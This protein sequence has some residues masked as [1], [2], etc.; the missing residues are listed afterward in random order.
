MTKHN[1][2]RMKL[3]LNLLVICSGIGGILYGYDIGVISGALV[4]MR[5]TISMTDSQVGLLVGSVLGGSLVGAII[6]GVLADHFGRRRMLVMACLVFF[7]GITIIMFANTYEYL[8]IARLLLGVGVGIISVAIPLY[9]AEIAPASIRGK[10]VA[11]FQLFLTLGILSAYGIDLIFANSGDWRF[12]FTIILLP[13]LILFIGMLCLPESPRWLMAKGKHDLAVQV[14]R[15]IRAPYFVVKEAQ[16]INLSLQ[17]KEG[18]WRDLFSRDLAK[19]LFV[20][21]SVAVFNQLTGISVFLQYAP[22]MLQQAGFSSSTVSMLGTVGIGVVNFLTTLLALSLIDRVGR[23]NL[24]VFGT[25][26]IVC[27][28]AFLGFLTKLHLSMH[29]Q[30]S[31]SLYGFFVFIFSFAIGPGVVVWLAISELYPTKVRGKGM[32][33]CLFINSLVASIL[34][35][36]FLDLI[37]FIGSGYTYL[38]FSG[39]TLCYFMIAYFLLPETKKQSLES[40]QSHFAKI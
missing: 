21:L 25:I 40:I 2:L 18:S 1:F 33:V 5:N 39:F 10:S 14:L 16:E 22:T 23:K 36:F 28:E 37:N 8:L 20:S 32:A 11:V 9:I 26:G 4:F 34:S 38:L 29:L 17:E 19:P 31:L 3:L 30:A 7:S 13:A 6:A 12:M 15:R 24:L 27:S 35:T